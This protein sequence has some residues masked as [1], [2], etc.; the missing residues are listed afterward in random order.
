MSIGQRIYAR[1][2]QL[3]MT[4]TE[5]S[6]KTGICISALSRIETGVVT[7]PHAGSLKKI[8]KA[9]R[10]SPAELLDIITKDGDI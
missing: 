6:K 10:Y 2:A 7:K 8:A 1:R 3:G 9:L 5:L 4:I